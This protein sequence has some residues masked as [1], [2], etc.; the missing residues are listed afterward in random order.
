MC[1]PEL[2]LEALDAALEPDMEAFEPDELAWEGLGRDADGPHEPTGRVEDFAVEERDR[3]G[4]VGDGGH[5][6]P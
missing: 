6:R 2:G 1:R 3:L 5:Q 4:H